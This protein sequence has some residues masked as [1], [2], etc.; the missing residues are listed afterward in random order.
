[1]FGIIE[2]S[3]GQDNYKQGF[4]FTSISQTLKLES[5]KKSKPNI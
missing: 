3:N 5:I 2:E 1:M 4:V